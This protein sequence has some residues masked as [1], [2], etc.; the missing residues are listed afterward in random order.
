MNII[1]EQQNP[2]GKN[3]WD[4][5]DLQPKKFSEPARAGPAGPAGSPKVVLI[6]PLGS[7]TLLKR[8]GALKNNGFEY[9]YYVEL[10]CLAK[11][12]PKTRFL[13]F[14]GVFGLFW[15][16]AGPMA[17]LCGQKRPKIE[18]VIKKF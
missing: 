7:L 9:K 12:M 16:P 14:L 13:A 2:W 5:R 4:P 3:F 10:F 18:N 15:G 17:Q 6:V 1:F 11:V 8:S